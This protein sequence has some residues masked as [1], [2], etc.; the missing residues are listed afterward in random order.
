MSSISL[1]LKMMLAATACAGL[2]L[3]ACGDDSGGG[4][5]SPSGSKADAGKKSDA[6]KSD[7]GKKDAAIE[8]PMV[9]PGDD[10]DTTTQAGQYAGVCED[11]TCDAPPCYARCVDGTYTDCKNQSEWVKELLG[12]GGI[13]GFLKDG[14]LGNLLKDGSIGNILGDGGNISVNRDAAISV[15][16]S[17]I[18]TS[19]C[20]SGNVCSSSGSGDVAGT[21][22]GLAAGEGMGI[23]TKDG[24]PKACETPADCSDYGASA[25]FDTAQVGVGGLVGLIGWSTKF[26][27]APCKP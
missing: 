13:D 6:G 27:M 10:C 4:S 25:C 8:L 1:S 2:T 23:C 22:I 7:A 24:T 20:P 9:T 19:A 11:D 26:C 3:A 16:D 15:S 5:D 17:G 12:D 21:I 14:G 18:P